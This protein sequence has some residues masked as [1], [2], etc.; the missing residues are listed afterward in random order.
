MALT[1]FD[2]QLIF[3]T[4]QQLAEGVP[5]LCNPGSGK[6]TRLVRFAAEDAVIHVV[7]A[8]AGCVFPRQ[9][10]I[11]GQTLEGLVQLD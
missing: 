8:L 10:H 7:G 6:E 9:R 3:L 11:S 5:A 2:C 1:V 4:L